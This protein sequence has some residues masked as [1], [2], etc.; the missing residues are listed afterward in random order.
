MRLPE[1]RAPW[2]ALSEL[3]LDT[4]LQE[5]DLRF[6]ART[7]AASG[8]SLSQ[9]EETLW[10]EVAPVVGWNL[11]S[12]AGVWEGFD[13]AWLEERVSRGRQRGRLLGSLAARLSRRLW[14][15]SIQADWERVKSLLP[16]DDAP[17]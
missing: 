16:Q 11:L 9:L 2:L 1:R 5:T 7:L 6:I 10:A 4:E 15:S 14:R 17:A 3:F 8:H 12:V 13:P